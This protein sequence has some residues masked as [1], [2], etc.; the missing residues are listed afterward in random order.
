V[1]EAFESAVPPDDTGSDVLIRFRYQALL[2]FGLCL[3]AL[4]PEEQFDSVACEHFEDIAV[5]DRRGWRLIQVKTRN[6]DRGAWKVGDLF[7]QSGPLKSLYRTHQ[8]LKTVDDTDDFQLVAM[9]EGRIAAGDTSLPLTVRP[10]SQTRDSI[11][12]TCVERL[13]ITEQEAEE[14]LARVHLHDGLPPREVADVWVLKRLAALAPHRTHQE[15]ADARERLLSIIFVAMRGQI[16]A[17][18]F[19]MM[20]V[21]PSSVE[22]QAARTFQ[23]KRIG[24]DDVVSILQPLTTEGGLLT[25]VDEDVALTATDL[26]HKMSAAGVPSAVIKD[27]TLL[28]ANAVRRE[29]EILASRLD[30]SALLQDLQTRVLTVG[31]RAAGLV[32]PGTTGNQVWNGAASLFSAEADRIDRHRL[33]GQDDML[34]L[35]ELCEVSDQCRFNWKGTAPADEEQPDAA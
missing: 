20:M 24:L 26:V 27:A 14:F 34:L 8:S 17:T 30:A 21:A 19:H 15:L 12:R 4:V 3:A 22:E 13:E 23:S 7:G 35:G 33:L 16:D 5:C 32:Q 1:A 11:K 18:D 2:T 9:L 10:T 25:E 28:R 29:A 6:A 31:N